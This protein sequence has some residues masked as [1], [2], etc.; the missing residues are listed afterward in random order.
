MNFELFF[1]GIVNYPSKCI[2]NVL[3]VV[4]VNARALVRFILDFVKTL[5]E[6]LILTLVDA[7]H[8]HVAK[9]L[10][11]RMRNVQQNCT[12]KSQCS[13]VTPVAG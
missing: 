8:H 2:A 11:T 5:C 13:N 4:V 3:T 1:Q 9:K 10:L 12:V 6:G 7:Y